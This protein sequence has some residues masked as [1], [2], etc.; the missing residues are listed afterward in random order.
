MNE[1]KNRK[2]TPGNLTGNS[3]KALAPAMPAKMSGHQS[4][5]GPRKESTKND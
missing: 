2:P 5:V 4:G 1:D 3:P